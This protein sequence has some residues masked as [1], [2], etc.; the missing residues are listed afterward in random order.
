MLTRYP[1]LLLF[2]LLCLPHTAR[3]ELTYIGSSTIGTGILNAGAVEAFREK[4]GKKFSSV[5]M[6][7]SGKGI[8]A[9]IEGETELAGVSRS[10]RLEE[11]RRGL[12]PFLIGYDAIAVFVHADNPVRNLSRKQLKQ[13]FTGRVTKWQDV[14]GRAASISP[15]TEI[16]VGERATIEMF[17]EIVMDGAAYGDFRQVDLSRDQLIQLARN[18]NGI[19]AASVGLVASL[20]PHVRK[21]IRA[22]SVNG[23]EPTERNVRSGGYVISRPLLLVT[24]GSPKGDHKD[25]IDFLLSPAGQRIVARNFVPVSKQR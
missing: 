6:P 17:R 18:Q 8:K 24:K 4:S 11:K 2:I 9:L 12:T 16:L 13:I 3:G 20:P 25:F 14:G 23:V 19:C 15:T 10:L 22:I 5:Q 21:K 7:G 1:L